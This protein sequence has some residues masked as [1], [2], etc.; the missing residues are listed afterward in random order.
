MSS[1][2]T[3]ALISRGLAARVHWTIGRASAATTE[4]AVR[5]GEELVAAI[6]AEAEQ[7][8]RNGVSKARAIHSV[9]DITEGPVS[10]AHGNSVEGLN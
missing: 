8:F 6:Q 4:E 9:P 1:P 3:G 10:S 2:N 5:L 7:A